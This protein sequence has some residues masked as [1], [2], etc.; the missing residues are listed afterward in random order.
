MPAVRVA[1]VFSIFPAVVRPRRPN[2]VWRG[3]GAALG[4]GRPVPVQLQ[5]IVREAD[6]E[7]FAPYFLQPAQRESPEPAS[8]LDLPEHRFHR[9]FPFAI[10]RSAGGIL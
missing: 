2:E 1:A 3:C 6:Q 8:L 4:R 10:E 9:L 5:Q 7:P